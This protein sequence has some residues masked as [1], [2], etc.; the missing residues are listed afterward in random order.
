MHSLPTADVFCKHQ[1]NHTVPFALQNFKNTGKSAAF[2][3][4][5]PWAW[6]RLTCL[7]DL[8]VRTMVPFRCSD[9]ACFDFEISVV[10]TWSV[11]GGVLYEPHLRKWVGCPFLAD[12]PFTTS[13][14][15]SDE[16]ASDRCLQSMEST[17]ALIANLFLRW[18][19]HIQPLRFAQV[20]CADWGKGDHLK[21]LQKP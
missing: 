9:F 5:F 11:T 20:W 2:W 18:V 19:W 6:L 21:L 7:C 10:V 1:S 14:D 15:T 8:C 3:C 13:D 4:V 16:A 17:V 12:W